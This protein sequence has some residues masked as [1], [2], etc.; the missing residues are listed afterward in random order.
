MKPLEHWLSIDLSSHR[1][2]LAI[3]RLIENKQPELL[4]SEAIT[5]HGNH[6]ETLIPRLDDVL[7]ALNLELAALDRL[8][9]ISGPGSFTGLR[10]GMASLKALA[11]PLN[12]PID[13]ISGS[14][15]RGL[16]WLKNN[17]PCS[18]DEIHVITF[19]TADKFV[20]GKFARQDNQAFQFVEESNHTNWD[21]LSTSI[22]TTVL[23]SDEKKLASVPDLPHLTKDIQ[24]LTADIIG[25]LLLRCASR[26]TY[27][28]L[29]DWVNAS[30]NYFGSSRF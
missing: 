12:I 11:Y 10:I 1:G 15:V 7:K 16:A 6:T 20:S 2:T 27:S 3:H 5:E 17:S 28:A 26:K 19:I 22:N 9:T 29:A 30:P 21:F 25:E 13:I 14:E 24:T 4:R 8:I 18:S 23:L